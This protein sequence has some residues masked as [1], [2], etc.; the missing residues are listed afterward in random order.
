MPALFQRV[1]TVFV[2]VRDLGKAIEW[3]TKTLGLGVRWRNDEGGYAAIEIGGA[4]ITFEVVKDIENFKPYEDAAFIIFVSDIEEA[5]K[6]L[7]SQGVETGPVETLYDVKWF[8]FKDQ[9]GN[10]LKACNF[11]E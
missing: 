3:Y 9:D 7:N 10:M 6:G 5:H 11:K 2:R 8:W 1:D 4:P